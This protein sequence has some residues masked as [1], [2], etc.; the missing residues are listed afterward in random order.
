M[1]T[2]RVSID[3]VTNT[4]NLEKFTL[5]GGAST[6]NSKGLNKTPANDSTAYPQLTGRLPTT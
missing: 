3:K 6:W 2:V 1:M 4:E 5:K